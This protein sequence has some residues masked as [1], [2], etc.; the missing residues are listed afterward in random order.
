MADSRVYRN[1]A[2]NPGSF[3]FLNALAKDSDPLIRMQFADWL[4]ENGYRNAAY[5]Q[6]WAA[7]FNKR[8][9]HPAEG[10]RLGEKGES[11]FSGWLPSTST[12]G[13][14]RR[15]TSPFAR[16]PGVFFNVNKNR[17]AR[18]MAND[19]YNAPPFHRMFGH[20]KAFLRASHGVNFND[21]GDIQSH[22]TPDEGIL[23]NS[24]TVFP[25]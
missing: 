1:A 25:V 6:R 21:E 4:D 20:E 7:N 8:P 15:E 13:S 3:K 2:D 12:P 9:I 10:V 17:H 18:G 16:L 5:A 19:D 14:P 23:H 22:Y 11:R 24:D